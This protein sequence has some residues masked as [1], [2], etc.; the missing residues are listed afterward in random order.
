MCCSPTE[1]LGRHHQ[2]VQVR[3]EQAGQGAATR[4]VQPDIPVAYVVGPSLDQDR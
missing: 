2:N 3:G 4:C 1:I